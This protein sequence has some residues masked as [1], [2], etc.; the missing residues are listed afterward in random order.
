VSWTLARA[1]VA[2]T[3]HEAQAL[4]CQDSCYASV[5]T[6]GDGSAV[7]VALAA[8]GAGSAEHG[9]LGAETA[10]TA[11][12]RF[13]AA[14][15]GETPRPA[16]DAALAEAVL[17]EVR[18][19]LAAQ[20]EMTGLPPRAFACTLLAAVCSDDGALL[21][22]VGDGAVVTAPAAAPTALAAALWPD[23]LQRL[24]LNFGDRTVHAP[25]FAPLFGALRAARESQADTLDEALRRMLA[26]EAINTRTDDDK[27]LV[28]A[29]RAA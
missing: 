6:A 16:L 21:A 7:L 2:G 9:G 17:A 14:R 8:D 5:E 1:S 22:Q 15:L 12:A 27:T 18:Q 25:F 10:M 3:A 23:G 28:L 20:A 24:T 19:A 26:S 13:L 29:V 4:P 11:A